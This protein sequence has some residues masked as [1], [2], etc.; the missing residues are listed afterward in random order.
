M[1]GYYLF[2]YFFV[3]LRSLLSY[4]KRS[5]INYKL[6]TLVHQTRITNKI[7]LHTRTTRTII[8]GMHLSNGK[9]FK[10]KNPDNS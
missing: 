7:L 2:Q 1:I 4:P 8:V 5:F 9:F 10:K 6:N 3:L